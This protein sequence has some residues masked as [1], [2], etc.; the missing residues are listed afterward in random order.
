MAKKPFHLA[1]FLSQGYGPKSWLSDWPGS[2][3][4]I[5]VLIGVFLTITV[6]S[7]QY[8]RSILPPTETSG[9]SVKIRQAP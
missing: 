2:D 4:A 8:M 9:A 6:L 5:L 1:W 3:L 7:I